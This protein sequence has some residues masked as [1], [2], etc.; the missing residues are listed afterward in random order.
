MR[1]ADNNEAGRGDPEATEVI[2]VPENTFDDEQMFED[3]EP[4][5]HDP[6]ATEVIA[7]PSNAFDEHGVPEA[8]TGVD[9]TTSGD[10]EVD[11]VDDSGPRLVRRWRQFVEYVKTDDARR[12]LPYAAAVAAL[13]TVGIG[14]WV[15]T[16]VRGEDSDA[17]SDAADASELSGTQSFDD[18]TALLPGGY[19]TTEVTPTA[20]GSVSET[21]SDVPPPGE[22]LSV[23]AGASEEPVAS[24]A[25]TITETAPVGAVSADSVATETTTE[26]QT[27]TPA[28]STITETSAA[29]Q[30]PNVSL[31]GSV[32]V[33]APSPQPRTDT[34]QTVVVQPSTVTV[35]VTVPAQSTSRS[36]APS[37]TRTTTPKSTSCRP[38][39][40]TTTKPKTTTTTARPSVTQTQRPQPST[41]TSK[42]PANTSSSPRPCG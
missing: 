26:T 8:G 2:R 21:P 23:A 34:P 10:V 7:L 3:N 31:N 22:E 33:Q 24:D 12:H 11:P 4:E 41:T 27:E 6:E 29:S 25:V 40:T 1:V 13:I 16:G 39:A 20:S 14:I 37:V 35:T 18:I 5:S 15:A 36:A 32:S 17:V 38:P 30:W 42:K 28:P 9:G 19:S